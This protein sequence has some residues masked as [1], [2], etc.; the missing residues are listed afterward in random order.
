MNPA[1][2][3]IFSHLVFLAVLLVA[4]LPMLPALADINDRHYPRPDRTRW[5]IAITNFQGSSEEEVRLGRDIA[6]R[7][8]RRS[9]TFGPVSADRPG[10]LHPESRLPQRPAALWRLARHW[11]ASPGSGSRASPAQRPV[12]HRVCAFGTY[13]A[14][15]QL[16]GRAYETPP[17]NWR[18]VA[19]IVADAI[20]KRITGEDGYFD[21]RIVYVSGKRPRRAPG[22]APRD[23]GP[24]RRQP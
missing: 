16:V 22:Q 21:T 10:G 13:S 4:A 12:A 2:R 9:R 8:D 18:R 1:A 6:P 24:G 5:P 23:H 17:D 11:R 20:Y 15:P 19:H 3:A 7:A 14:R